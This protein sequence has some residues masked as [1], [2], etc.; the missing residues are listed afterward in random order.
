MI[1]D[2]R[3]VTLHPRLY[4][5]FG[6][7]KIQRHDGVFLKQELFRLCQYLHSFAGIQG[8]G[9]LGD[10][11]IE[12]K[13]A[14]FA[15]GGDKA[16]MV[17]RDCATGKILWET[18]NP[19][20]LRMTH[21]SIVPLEHW[22]TRMYIYCTS[23]GIIGVSAEDGK[24]LWRY[25]DWQV[26]PALSPSPVIIGDEQIF[27]SAA[28]KAGCLMLKM[29]QDDDGNP[30]AVKMYKR[31]PNIFGSVQQTPL[32]HEKHLYGVLTMN[33]GE[34]KLQMVCI[35]LDGMRIWSSGPENRFE[36][37]PYLI[38]DGK[39][40]A[41]DGK[42]GTLTMARAT[43]A[44]WEMLAK[45]PI[46]DGHEAWAPMAIADGRL[47]LRDLTKMICLDLRDP[48]APKPKKTPDN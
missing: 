27:L 23:G 24:I 30:Q 5:T 17:A 33:A 13:V 11:T 8:P 34:T 12:Q 10:K 45:A 40:L 22:G 18:P 26:T 3:L 39:I 32:F 21:S 31:G 20:K 14:V 28:Y 37:G 4:K 48:N 25:K 2:A 19:D 9:S 41:L 29:E 43:P 46:L 7:V 35:N 44:G 36:L 1:H 47:I 38:A 42:T 16:L 15:P 6:D